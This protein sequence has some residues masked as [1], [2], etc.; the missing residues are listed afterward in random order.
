MIG[1]FECEI[2]KELVNR[3][4]HKQ[5]FC[6]YACREKHKQNEVLRKWL[7][8]KPKKRVNLDT[9]ARMESSAVYNKT[10][11]WMKKTGR[12]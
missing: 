7:E 2:C 8:K 6:S 5:R 12:C 9:S 11:G 3:T 1:Q 4:H 10:G